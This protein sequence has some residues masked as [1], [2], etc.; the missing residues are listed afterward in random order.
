MTAAKSIAIK[1]S[2][3]LSTL[4]FFL[5]QL[6]QLDF[7]LHFAQRFTFVGVLRPTM[8]LFALITMLL[9]IQREKFKHRF[10]HPIF[11]A[12]GTFIFMVFIT[13]PFVAFP[14]SVIRFNIPIILKAIV[15]LYFTALILDTEKRYRWAVFTFVACQVFRVMEPLY[16]HITDGYWG[17]ITYY[18]GE[19]ANR[20]SGAPADVINPNE[21]GF[22][23]V[24]AIPFLH[25]L[26]LREKWHFKFLYFCLLAA[27]LYALLLTMSRGAF[28]ALLVVGWF[29]WK[30]SKRKILLLCMAVVLTVVAYTIMNDAQRDRYFSLVSSESKQSRTAE[31]RITGMINEFVVGLHR[32]IFGHGI[33]TSPE[34]KFHAGHSTKASHNMY[35]EILIE[36]GFVGMF[37]FFRFVRAIYRQIEYAKKALVEADDFLA[38]MFKIYNVVFWMFAVYSINY[39]GLSQYYWYNLAGLVIATSFLSGTQM[40]TRRMK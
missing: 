34:A 4:T 19:F 40:N 25:Y 16:L 17:S 27:L 13:L 2:A 30:E 33:G 15:F 7:F 31:G 39:W 14:G 23:I 3:V 21:L 6:Y 36:V 20:L 32:P 24:T 29:V 38:V 18:S 12:Y 37:F 28:L 10:T 26:L 1:E 5:F 11:S 8:L 22:I 9:I 35:A